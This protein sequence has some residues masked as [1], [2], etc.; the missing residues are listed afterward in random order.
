MNIYSLR[1][2]KKYNLQP[3]LLSL[4]LI[5]FSY[6]FQ[7]HIGLNL[8]DEGFLWYGSQRVMQGEV[9]IRDFMSYD[10]GRYYWSS[11]IMNLLGDDGIIALRKSVTVFQFL[12]LYCGLYLLHRWS[13]KKNLFNLTISGLVLLL[14]MFPRHKLFDISLSI[15]LIGIYTLI[16]YNP[17]LKNFYL[18]GLGLGLVAIFGRNHG[19][20]GFIGFIGLYI[21]LLINQYLDKKIIKNIIVFIL[22]IFTGYSPI[23]LMSIFIPGFF[24]AFLSSIEFIFQQKTTNL[25]L[26][27]P[28]PWTIEIQN[29]FTLYGIKDGI[30]GIYFLLLFFFSIFSFILNFSKF[31][32]KLKN[33]VLI[34]S[35]FLMIP[36]CHYAFSRADLGHLAQGIFP[37][38]IWTLF[39]VN[40]IKILRV[41]IPVT[42]LLSSIF[43][44]S[45]YHPG[46]SCI[47]QK[48]CKL[49]HIQGEELLVDPATDFSITYLSKLI[50]ENSKN[51]EDFIVTPF[52]PG[53]FAIYRKKS[54]IWEIYAL[55]PRN[56]KFEEAEITRIEKSNISFILVIDSPLDNR[57]ELRYSSTHPILYKY[58]NENFKY[59]PLLNG[60]GQDY[61][62]YLRK[63]K[64]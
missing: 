54:P 62:V 9:P 1:F 57:E 25:P 11:A 40:K 32:G 63:D 39:L 64:Y 52:W 33:P 21:Y 41:T 36:Y 43:I 20:Y 38:L 50:Q 53:S 12:G 48:N 2:T 56:E 22:G 18:T 4:S 45:Y 60:L 42:L 55:W 29:L 31:K 49:T 37:F 35:S 26:P 8:W 16:I 10:V 28:W 6:F 19:F 58:I 44:F 17:T 47:I 14:W 34:S 15:L 5:L 46:T 51:N 27:V 3:L 13:Q 59:E 23:I 30:I 61:K 7:A 24:D